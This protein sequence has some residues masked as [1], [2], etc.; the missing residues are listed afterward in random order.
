MKTLRKTRT[1]SEE[2][3]AHLEMLI[4]LVASGDKQ[5]FRDLYERVRTALF[6]CALRVVGRR[7][8]AEDV[9]QEAFLAIWKLSPD[10]SVDRGSAL[11]WMMVITRTRGVDILRR[12]VRGR[13][14][15]TFGFEEGEE[16]SLLSDQPDLGKTLDDKRLQAA[17]SWSLSQLKSTQRQVITLA[18]LS[19]MSHSEVALRTGMPIGT[20]KTYVRRGLKNLREVMITPLSPAHCKLDE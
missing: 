15:M 10:Y 19:D 14:N 12:R 4:A 6:Y 11:A 16:E 1:C 17:A 7:E 8:I 20:V 18:Y 13:E 9:L 3:D 2:G 5:A